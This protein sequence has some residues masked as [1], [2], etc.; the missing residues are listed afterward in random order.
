VNAADSHAPGA[1]PRIAIIGGGITG[2]AAA[3]RL[4]ELLPQ[5]KLSLFEASSRLGG[6]LDT[7]HID[8]FL[9]ERSADNFLTKQPVIMDLCRRLGLEPELLATDETRRR[10][11]V[12]KGGQLLPIPEG[13]FLMSPQRLRPFLTSPVLSLA[14]KLRVLI[15]PFVPRGASA[16]PAGDESVASFARR[17]LGQEAFERLV[18]PLVAG[19]YTGDPEK[20][21]MAA[22]M[23]QF[24]QQEREHRSLLR[25]AW[26]TGRTNDESTNRAAGARYSLFAAPQKGI[27]RLCDA[28]IDCLPPETI[29]LNSP[30]KTIQQSTPTRWK[31]EFEAP[32]PA[33]NIQRLPSDFSAVILAVPAYAAARLLEPCASELAAELAAIEYA[34]CAVVSLGFQRDRVAHPLDGFGFVVPQV[35]RRRIIAASFASQKFPGRAPTDSVLF[36]VFVGGALQPELLDLPDMELCQLA[37]DELAGLLQISGE[38]VMTDI[39]RWPRSMPQY[40]VGHLDRV[41]RI[42]QMVAQNPTLALAGNAYHGVGIPQ[43]VASAERAAARLTNFFRPA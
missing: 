3:L 22:A 19:I 18:Q 1:A 16:G 39:A 35:E 15:E 6:V 33:S 24:C 12:V 38:P 20:L 10:A 31:L 41:A 30:V 32:H 37:V 21:S 27:Q 40:H 9:V 13:F 8:G 42:E 2:L 36:R 29:H 25:A 5:A 4:R 34:G 17:R 28:L 43:C 7:A 11:F 14:G 26:K 23:P